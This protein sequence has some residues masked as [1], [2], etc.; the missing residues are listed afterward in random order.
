MHIYIYIYIIYIYIYIRGS[1][2]K[3]PD[4]FLYRIL[5]LSYTLENSLCYCYTSYEI[6]DQFL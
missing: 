6:T 4:F 5:E 1:F 3:F 2:N